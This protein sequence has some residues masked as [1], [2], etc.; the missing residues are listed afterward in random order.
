[1]FYNRLH[2]LQRM[3]SFGK[4][5]KFVICKILSI[6]THC[7]VETTCL[8]LV[9]IHQQ[10]KL[11]MKG[12][13]ILWTAC[14][15]CSFACVF[16]FWQRISKLDVVLHSV[17]HLYTVDVILC[18]CCVMVA[19]LFLSCC[20]RC[21]TVLHTPYSAIMP[22]KIH[23]IALCCSRLDVSMQCTMHRSKYSVFIAH[24]FLGCNFSSSNWYFASF[25]GLVS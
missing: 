24:L 1:M 15:S 9:H 3:S 7:C 21:R 6:K 16:I 4:W 13:W 2:P 5:P 19:S 20:H 8:L 14:F 23:A 12:V 25:C 11:M 17:S 22:W 10:W 18:C